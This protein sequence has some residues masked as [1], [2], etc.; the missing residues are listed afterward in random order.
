LWDSLD[1]R[2]TSESSE[3]GS[4]CFEVRKRRKDIFENNQCQGKCVL[5]KQCVFEMIRVH[6]LGFIH[7][8]SIS[9]ITQYKQTLY[10]TTTAKLSYKSRNILYFFSVVDD[11]RTN[12][13]SK[14][15]ARAV[16]A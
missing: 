2:A 8:T 16:K 4:A 1:V 6:C 10:K 3:L 9:N 15:D 14:R 5:R 11:C 7:E 13:V 12:V